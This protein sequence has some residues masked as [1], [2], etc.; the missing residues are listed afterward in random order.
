[1]ERGDYCIHYQGDE[2]L[3]IE[4]RNT[5]KRRSISARLHGATSQ[6]TIIFIL[7]AART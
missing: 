6:N 1:M 4:A 2:P 7:A 3:M 5:L